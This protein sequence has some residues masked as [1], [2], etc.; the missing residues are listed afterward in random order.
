MVAPY[1]HLHLHLRRIVPISAWTLVLGVVLVALTS[2]TWR[3]LARRWGWRPLPTAVALLGLS[4]ALALTLSPRHWRVNHRNLHQCLPHDWT[5]LAHA[6]SRVGGSLENLLNIA[7]LVPLGFGLAL[8]SRRVWWPALVVVLVPAA[9]ELAQV[10]IPGRE[11][12]TADWLAN[13]LG[14]LLGALVGALLS[15]VL[16]RRGGIRQT[17]PSVRRP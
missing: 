7:M 3:P 4:G 16:D 9:V 6:A 5:D 1:L 10:M 14:G 12:S 11:C 15:A 2:V 17:P 13:A 8:A